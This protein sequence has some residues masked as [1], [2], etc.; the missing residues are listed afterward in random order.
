MRIWKKQKNKKKQ[1]RRRKAR[2]LPL[3]LPH[4]SNFIYDYDDENCNIHVGSLFVKEKDE[5]LHACAGFFVYFVLFNFLFKANSHVNHTL[6]EFGN[7]FE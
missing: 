5:T 7:R 3:P 4:L 6:Y 2:Y 1:N